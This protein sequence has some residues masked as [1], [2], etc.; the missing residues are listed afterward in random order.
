MSRSRW[1]YSRISGVLLCFFVADHIFF[2]LFHHH[3]QGIFFAIA[4]PIVNF[5][6]LILVASH[7]G[8][9]VFN[10]IKDQRLSRAARVVA[11][12]SISLVVL[13]LSVVGF[14]LMI[15]YHLI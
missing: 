7:A 4:K 15:N 12:W 3:P 11:G 13:G 2:N 5:I 1:L 14:Q 8:V 9:G 10:I 6:L